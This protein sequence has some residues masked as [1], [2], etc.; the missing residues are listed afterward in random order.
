MFIKTEDRWCILIVYNI[1][2]NMIIAI[3]SNEV[4]DKVKA[5]I[6]AVF[7]IQD[8]GEDFI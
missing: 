4:I 8:L 2:D 5:D 1:V 6:T 3:K 7:E